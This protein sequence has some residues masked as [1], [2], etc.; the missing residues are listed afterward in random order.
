MLKQ[1]TSFDRALFTYERAFIGSFTF[2]TGL[3]RLDFDRVEIA[4][5]LLAIPPTSYVSHPNYF[6]HSSKVN[7]TSKA[8]CSEGVMC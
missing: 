8:I 3:N 4:R 1:S 2:T 6:T 7:V 5:S